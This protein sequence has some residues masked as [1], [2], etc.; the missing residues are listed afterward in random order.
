[1]STTIGNC[2]RSINWYMPKKM[3]NL[4][5]TV[6]AISMLSMMLLWFW[7]WLPKGDLQ[8]RNI[9]YVF[10]RSPEKANVV[11]IDKLRE[12]KDMVTTNPATKD[13]CRPENNFVFIKTSKTGG[14]TLANI[15]FRYGVKKNLVAALDADHIFAIDYN[16]TEDIYN[17]LKYNCSDFPGY[18]FMANH[19]LY[20]RNAMD[21]VVNNAKYITIFRSPES[22]MK[23]VYYA[24]FNKELKSTVFNTSNPFS[25]YL[26]Q[27]DA[28]YSKGYSNKFIY[29]PHF[30]SQTFRFGIHYPDN[31]SVIDAKIK[32]LDNELDL[33]LLTDFYDESL[34][35]LKKIM[36]WDFEDILYLPFKVHKKEEPPITL[37]M[38]KIM[39][40]L[41]RPDSKLYEH[42]NNT[43]WDKV[44]NYDGDFTTDLLKFRSMKQDLS[45]KCEIARY[46]DNCNLFYTD[47]VPMIH[48]MLEKQSKWIC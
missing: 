34:L 19:I 25:E 45:L 43:L 20:H 26:K 47:D 41:M 2:C 14:S 17:I 8:S 36:C 33:V 21:N 9:I 27:I 15:F 1:M 31:E 22:H 48:M 12:N 23:S 13:T 30:N 24:R 11:E 37:E 46:S 40:R 28:E 29:P 10:D 39:G 18:N 7:G 35:L 16:S 3:V 5:I 6:I 38:S 44:R 42:F 4:L 32:R